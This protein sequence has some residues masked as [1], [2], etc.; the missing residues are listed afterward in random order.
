M[1]FPLED[2]VSSFG[3]SLSCLEVAASDRLLLR[4][5]TLAGFSFGS[6]VD[7]INC[8]SAIF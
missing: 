2:L 1:S 7:F 3:T 4:A 5:A 6:G 8:F